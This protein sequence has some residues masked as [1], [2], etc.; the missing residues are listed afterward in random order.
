MKEEEEP[1]GGKARRKED[2]RKLYRNC[3][4]KADIEGG[5]LEVDGGGGRRV[6]INCPSVYWIWLDQ[7]HI[8]L[9]NLDQRPIFEF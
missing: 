2:M 3:M 5:G 9:D 1:E 8:I 7:N 4:R 6:L